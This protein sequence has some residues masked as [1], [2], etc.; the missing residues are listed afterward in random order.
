MQLLTTVFDKTFAVALFRIVLAMICGGLI[1][2]ERLIHGRAAGM[3][4]HILVCI[5][6]A[7]TVMTGLYVTELID[8]ASDPM[9]IGAQVISGIGF[10]GVGTILVKGNSEVTGLTTAAGLWTTAAIG[11]AIGAGFYSGAIIATFVSFLAVV[12]LGRMEILMMHK[13]RMSALYLEIDSVDHINSVIDS[14]S[15]IYG[16]SQTEVTP[17]RSATVGNVG[18][19]IALNYAAEKEKKQMMENLRNLH[20]VVLVLESV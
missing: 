16:M 14:I 17:P 9:R 8:A 11:L 20:H 3:R 19:E 7:L 2:V 4:T 18:L 1:G 13:R 12:V 5:G 6:S 15:A 10:L